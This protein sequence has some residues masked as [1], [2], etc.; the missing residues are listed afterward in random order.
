M[1]ISIPAS[2]LEP[3]PAYA[4]KQP[5]RHAGLPITSVLSA[6]LLL[7]ISAWRMQGPGQGSPID[8]SSKEGLV[9]FGLLQAAVQEWG[10]T[11]IMFP[12]RAAWTLSATLKHSVSKD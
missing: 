11:D 12:A 10:Q 3:C 1:D 2:A 7:I 8:N 5:F 9:E 4:G 6:S